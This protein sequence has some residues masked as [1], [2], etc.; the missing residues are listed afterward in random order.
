MALA[1]DLGAAYYS[2]TFAGFAMLRPTFSLHFGTA[3]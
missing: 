2:G 1:R 3:S